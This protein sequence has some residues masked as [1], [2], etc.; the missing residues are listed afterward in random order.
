MDGAHLVAQCLSA[1]VPLWQP[2]IRQF[3]TPVQT[4]HSLASHAVVDVPHIK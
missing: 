4:W 3:G 1:H 2:G